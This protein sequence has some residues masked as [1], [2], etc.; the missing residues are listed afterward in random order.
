M[1][2]QK[3]T[4]LFV[5]MLFASNFLFAVNPKT[6]TSDDISNSMV[7]FVHSDVKLTPDQKKVLKMKAKEYADKLMQARVMSDREASYV[8]MKTVSN[9]YE[10]VLDSVLTADQ[11]VLKDK[12]KKERM[13]FIT[14]GGK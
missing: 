3:T 2:N 5:A 12:K 13:D 4:V 14:N 9:N 7:E 8:F 1:K 6:E 11:K 10:A